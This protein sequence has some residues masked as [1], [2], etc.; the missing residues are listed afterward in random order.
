M[1]IR[2]QISNP[3][4]SFGGGI[5]NAGAGLFSSTTV[6]GNNTLA[7]ANCS[8]CSVSASNGYDV[9]GP[10]TSSNSLISQP[11]GATITDNG[12]NLFNVDPLLDPAGLKFN[13][14]PTETV[15][16]ESGSPAIDAV[17]V[18][19]CTDLAAPPNPL[20]IDQRGF[21]RPDV[22]ETNC[23]MGA[24]EVQ[25]TAFLPF[26]HFGGNLK[27]D[28]DAGVFYLNGGFQLG[29]GGN[30]DPTKQP[31]AFGVGSYAIRLP[32]GSF[33]KYS[34]GYVYQKK[35]NGIF[36]CL[37]IKF[38]STPGTYQLLANRFGGTLTDTNS[39]VPVTLTVGDDSGTT[40]MNAK[41]Y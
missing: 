4:S 30:I 26:S 20:I 32:V 34:T 36:L 24:Y 19:N 15:A 25:D 12:G 35:V 39:P 11:A 16:L 9:H 14:G 37:F 3:G 23:D 10:I 5:A 17:P 18:A 38:T 31:V 6:I 22:G 29:S 27:I 7:Y 2:Y 8:D 40:L 13:G 28:P 21:P 33:V 41:F 1:L